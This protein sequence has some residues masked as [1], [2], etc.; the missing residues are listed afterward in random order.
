MNKRSILRLKRQIPLSI[1]SLTTL[2]ILPDVCGNPFGLFNYFQRQ[3]WEILRLASSIPK[4]EGIAQYIVISLVHPPHLL[5]LLYGVF[6]DYRL[7][8]P[9][10]LLQKRT[11]F[12]PLA[13]AYNDLLCTP[14]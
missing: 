7:V 9:C 11:A 10:K 12:A 6:P 8:Q 1:L 4:P 2:T 14:H 5:G 3:S 13:L